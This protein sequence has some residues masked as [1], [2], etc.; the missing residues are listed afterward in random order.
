MVVLLRK[1]RREEQRKK[2]VQ[3]ILKKRKKGKEIEKEELL[4]I[5]LQSGLT[6][7][8]HQLIMSGVDTLAPGT[9]YDQARHGVTKIM[10]SAKKK[11]DRFEL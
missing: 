1:R 8:E 2:K 5:V 10:G 7:N 9:L 11:S 4:S 3:K 6:E